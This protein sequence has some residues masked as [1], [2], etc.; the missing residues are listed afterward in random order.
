[1]RRGTHYI[2]KKV[3]LWESL[4]PLIFEKEPVGYVSCKPL[5]QVLWCGQTLGEDVFSLETPVIITVGATPNQRDLEIGR[6]RRRNK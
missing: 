1:M 2:Q 3:D 4:R 5:L 6:R